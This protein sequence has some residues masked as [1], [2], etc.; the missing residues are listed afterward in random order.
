MQMLH[1]FIRFIKYRC[2]RLGVSLFLFSFVAAFSLA[3][4]MPEEELEKLPPFLCS[5]IRNLAAMACRN[6]NREELTKG[7]LTYATMTAML[8]S[9]FY[10]APISLIAFSAL[11]LGDGLADPVGRLLGR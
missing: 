8:V 2:G 6:G 1:I 10:T 11:F 4:H 9:C 5:R 3:A 7:P